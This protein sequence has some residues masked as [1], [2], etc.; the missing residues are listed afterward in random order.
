VRKGQSG[1]GLLAIS[2][3]LTQRSVLEAHW[4]K[5]S[6]LRVAGK[7]GTDTP[8]G[9]NVELG[10][11]VA[12]VDWATRSVVAQIEVPCASGMAVSVD[13]LYVASM[14]ANYITVIDRK[15]QTVGRVTHRLI[16]DPHSVVLSSQR[17]LVT[18]SGVDGILDLDLAGKLWWSWLSFEHQYTRDQFGEVVD[19]S[20]SADHRR[21]DY[22]TLHQ[23]THVNSA[24]P[25]GENAVLAT[26]FHQGE[27]VEIDRA[28]GQSAVLDSGL[29]QPHSLR[30]TSA[31]F[32]VADTGV[33][34]AILYD[35]RF[36]RRALV[37]L[38]TNWL[39][40]AIHDESSGNWFLL[41]GQ[42]CRL[43]EVDSNGACLG[44]MRFNDDW[45]AFAIEE[46]PSRWIYE[47]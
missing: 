22:P 35:S 45:K 38:R 8:I 36:R 11:L 12:I 23:A 47:D 46:L 17:L 27:V 26:L 43:V 33:G 29:T 7:V 6:P 32:S 16:N 21:S 15:L 13:H 24:I 20:R 10:G 25:H 41:D 4:A 19:R 37:P 14:R 5:H 34:R 1:Q 28:S 2:I 3:V 31:G 40:D 39:A 42:R 30:A 9:R 18:S 44:E